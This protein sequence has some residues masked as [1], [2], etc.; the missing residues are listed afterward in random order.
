MQNAPFHR[1]LAVLLACAASPAFSADPSF[2]CREQQSIAEHVICGSSSLAEQDKQLHVLF[3][4]ALRI[5]TL[6]PKK[7]K[8]IRDSQK[9]WLSERN[10]C[11]YSVDCLQQA[12]QQRTLNLHTFIPRE[13]ISQGGKL[14]DKP[15]LESKVVGLTQEGQAIRILEKTEVVFNDYPWFKVEFE[16][17][18]AY[19]WGGLLCDSVY[20]SETQCE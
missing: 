13:S 19:Q 18:T 15:S 14:R 12:Y 17:L 7:N 3:R 4:E 5:S 6:N 9:Q 8:Q 10:N 20:A 1:R 16:G 11:Q 2:E